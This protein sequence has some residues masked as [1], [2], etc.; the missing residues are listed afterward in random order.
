MKKILAFLLVLVMALTSMVGCDVI[1]GLLGGT[2]EGP[3]LEEAKTYLFSTYKDAATSIPGDY[4]LVGKVIID[5]T[6]FAVTWTVDLDTITIKESSKANFWTVDLPD[7][8][9]TEVAYVLTATITDAAGNKVEV[10]FNKTLPVID[11]TGIV[12]EP[13]EGVAYKLFLEQVNLGFTLFATNKSQQNEKYIETTLDPKAAADYYVEKVDGGYKWYTTINGTKTYVLAQGIDNNGKVSKYI[14]FSTTD[15]SVF[16]YVQEISTWQVVINNI[17]YGVGTYNA[18]ETISISEVTY[19]KPDNINVAGGQFSLT[20]MTKTYAETLTPDEKPVAGDPEANSTLTIKQAIDLGNTKVKDQYTEGKYYVTGVITEV[21]NEQYGN[22]YITDGTNTLCIY[23]TYDATG[24]NSYKD[25]AVKP[26][27]GDTITVYGIIGKYNDPQ[28]KNGWITSHTPAEGGNTP[29]DPTPANGVELTSDKVY[30]SIPAEESGSY[31]SYGNYNG[32]YTYEGLSITTADVLRNSHGLPYVFQVKKASGVITISNVKVESVTIVL[33]SSYDSPYMPTIT[34]GGVE[35]TYDS[36]AVLATKEATGTK[37]SSDYDV[38]AFTITVATNSDVAGDLVISNTANGAMYFKSIVVATSGNGEGGNTD[39][40]TPGDSDNNE[41]TI[42]TSAPITDVAQLT[43]GTKIV[44]AG[45]TTDA[46]LGAQSGTLR[47]K[48]DITRNSDGSLTYA[49]NAGVSVLTLEL[50][51]D[52]TWAIKDGNVYLVAVEG[53]NKVDVTED[54]TNPLAKWTIEFVEGV[55]KIHTN[56][57]SNERFLQYNASSP[58]F[59]AYKASSNQ[60]D[61]VICTIE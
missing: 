41:S 58:R 2:E 38:Y 54:K 3:T 33:V 4:D 46:A 14:G 29:V 35:L 21:Y 31:P 59:V 1:S 13:E 42:T 9:A 25:M 34:F 8:N 12:T 50:N 37:N 6:S 52:G 60:Q 30:A 23:G 40:E 20:F 18:F 47:T 45:S 57:G 22:M 36:N 28:M 7:T 56:D 11:S 43:D 24:A 39:T 16:T 17:K 5:G 32:T 51:D 19:F 26:V 53:G 15:A 48:I 61:V 10:K 27:A 44:I 55:L 49:E